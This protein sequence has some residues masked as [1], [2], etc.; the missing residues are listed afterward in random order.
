MRRVIS[1]VLLLVNL[2]LSWAGSKEAPVTLEPVVVTATRTEVPLYRVSSPT[3][4]ITAEDISH[5]AVDNLAEI[6]RN[7]PGLKVTQLR[8]PG[9]Y[10][11]LSIRGSKSNQVLFLLDG[12]PLT[13]P[14]SLGNDLNMFLGQLL[15]EDIERVEII[16]G[17]QSTLYGSD[18]LGGVVNI[19][20]KSGEGKPHYR[21]LFEGG[22]EKSFREGL[23]SWGRPHPLLAYSFTYTRHVSDRIDEH[24]DYRNDTLSAKIDLTLRDDLDLTLQA[25]FLDTLQDLDN[26]DSQL[27]RNFD[28]P[29]YTREGHYGIQTLLLRHDPTDWWSHRLSLS[30]TQGKRSYHDNPNPAGY[31]PG[32]PYRGYYQGK[33]LNIDWQHNLFYQDLGVFT[34]GIEYEE[35]W[36]STRYESFPW[37][38]YISQMHRRTRNLAYYF[39][40]QL[41]LR[42]RF[43]LTMG[44][45]ID[46]NDDFGTQYNLKASLA[47]LIPRLKTKIRGNY[48]S[49]FKAPSLFQLYSSYGNPRLSPEESDSFDLGIEQSIWGDR[50]RLEITWFHLDLDDLISYDFSSRHYRNIS[51][52]KSQGLEAELVIT[53][54][55]GLTCRV[56]YTFINSENKATGKEL[57]G[58]PN[59]QLG[60]NINWGPGRGF[61]LNLDLTYVGDSQANESGSRVNDAYT[62][63]DLV[64][65]YRLNPRLRFYFRADNMF[66]EDIVENGFQGPPAWVYGGLEATF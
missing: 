40:D 36:A 7:V 2:Q 65:S 4:I 35:Q 37:G 10:T 42:E 60:L 54:L 24:D 6:L 51:K 19:I 47:Y 22:S 21:L 32:F 48:A 39:Q 62:K 11:T 3:T 1:V 18:A 41:S 29:N 13:D 15:T 50:V 43:F 26:F 28:D 25:R 14:S 66:D 8:G 20:T 55:A 63:V 5:Q 46:D 16:R 31:F 17:T 12:Q 27:Y 52:G 64:L 58:I 61:N 56:T 38:S 34:A 44:L 59:D 33:T 23:G 57:P 53:P 45:R 49:G 30:Q 9:S